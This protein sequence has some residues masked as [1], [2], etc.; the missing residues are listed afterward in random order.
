MTPSFVETLAIS[1]EPRPRPLGLPEIHSFAQPTRGGQQPQARV[2]SPPIVADKLRAAVDA[3]SIVSFV[4]GLDEE[5]TSDVL[6]SVQL[7]QRAANAKHDRFAATQG[8]YD[9]YVYV[10]QKLGWAVEAF[11]FA[12]KD[13]AKGEFS[14]DKSALEVI[15]TIATGAQLAILVKTIDTLKKLGDDD[16]ALRIFDIQAARDL[17]GNFQIGAAQKSDN[18]ALSL[19]LGAFHFEAKDNR[20]K[21]LFWSWGA[22]EIRFWTAVSKMTLNRDLYAAHRDAVVRKL[23]ADAGDYV[24]ELEIV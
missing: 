23:K 10:L 6:Y 13:K 16:R 15:A 5:E 20:G 9:C 14:M 18:A 19:A 4:A 3:G 21:F 7:A 8:W 24:A 17:S 22:E 1:H 12:E 2:A 11:A